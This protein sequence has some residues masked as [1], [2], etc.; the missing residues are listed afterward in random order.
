MSTALLWLAVGLIGGWLTKVPWYNRK[1]RILV[2]S[3][4]GSTYIRRLTAWHILRRLCYL[5]EYRDINGKDA[6]Y[7]NLKVKAWNDAFDIINEDKPFD[8]AKVVTIVND[9]VELDAAIDNLRI[10]SSGTPD[11]LHPSDQAHSH[12]RSQNY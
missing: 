8:S 9:I 2:E 12:P 7:D 4:D 5:K 6:T 11:S 1:Y 10:Q 3:R